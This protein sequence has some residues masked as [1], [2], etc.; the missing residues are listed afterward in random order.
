MKF[1]ISY[2]DRVGVVHDVSKVIYDLGINIISFQIYH[3]VIYIEIEDEFN[4]EN[5]CKKLLSIPHVKAVEKS[6]I[7]P[8]EVKEKQLKVVLDS[9]AEGVL[10]TDHNG[11]IEIVNLPAHR[12][13]KK[14]ADDLL[15][16]P[17]Q[18]ILN[19]DV[20]LETLKTG[21]PH[22]NNTEINIKTEKR[23]THFLISDVPIRDKNNDIIGVVATL[24]DMS[25]VKE[26]YFKLT[27]PPGMC[28]FDNNT[29]H[30]VVMAAV[31]A[32]LEIM[33]EEN[34][35]EKGYKMGQYLGSKLKELQDKHVCVGQVTGRGGFW[36]LDIDKN[37]EKQEPF[38]KEDR[39][40][41]CWTIKNWTAPNL[42]TE[43][44]MEKDVFIATFTPNAIPICPTLTW[45]N[46]H[47]DKMVDALDYALGFVDKLCD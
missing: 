34:L 35:V 32:N 23:K 14:S 43:K 21:I 45:T 24:R 20:L 47:I 10:A 41:E 27:P 7:I 22:Y 16:R 46:E 5:L 17:I 6:K 8:H 4:F 28:V 11:K 42:I 12:I 3:E 30:P 31:A 18:E 38:I 2:I 13:L 44:A 9:I 19:D 40:A 15:E 39:N 25:E 29:A 33:L 26:L 1:K 36:I 37:R